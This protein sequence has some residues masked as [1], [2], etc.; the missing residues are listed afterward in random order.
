MINKFCWILQLHVL[1]PSNNPIY[2]LE[3][4]AKIDIDKYL[5]HILVWKISLNGAW[6]SGKATGFGPD[7]RGFE[8]FRPRAVWFETITIW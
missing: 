8:S 6:P 1:N 4:W 5:Y 7:M 2:F 3:I